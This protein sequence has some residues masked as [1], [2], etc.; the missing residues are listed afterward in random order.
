MKELFKKKK[1]PSDS[2]K[3]EFSLIFQSYRLTFTE[4][5]ASHWGWDAQGP[6]IVATGQSSLLGVVLS[7]CG[8]EST[9]WTGF[10]LRLNQ[11]LREEKFRTPTEH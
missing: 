11:A 6:H 8:P 1:N 10:S 7:F 3:G 5:F 4:I 9:D 2:E